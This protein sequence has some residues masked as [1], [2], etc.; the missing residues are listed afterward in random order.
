L[1]FSLSTR[2]ETSSTSEDAFQE[3][4]TGKKQGKNLFHKFHKNLGC[5]ATTWNN[6]YKKKIF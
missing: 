4:I 5:R 3:G 6:I 1:S 2:K